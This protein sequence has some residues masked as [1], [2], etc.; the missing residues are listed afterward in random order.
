MRVKRDLPF[1]LSSSP[2]LSFPPS[3]PPPPPLQIAAVPRVSSER[4]EA[5][6]NRARTLLAKGAGACAASGD[7]S[8]KAPQEK[9][10]DMLIRIGVVTEAA[11]ALE[12][13]EACTLDGLRAAGKSIEGVAGHVSKWAAHWEGRSGDTADS[14]AGPRGSD[15]GTV[16]ELIPRWRLPIP[17][18][19]EV[20]EPQEAVVFWQCLARDLRIVTRVGGVER[21]GWGTLR[22]ILYVFAEGSPSLVPRT[23]MHMLVCTEGDGGESTVMTLCRGGGRGASRVFD[24]VAHVFRLKWRSASALPVVHLSACFCTCLCTAEHLQCS[25]YRPDVQTGPFVESSPD[26]RRIS[27]NAMSAGVMSPSSLASP[28][29]HQ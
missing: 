3:P 27:A 13:M 29:F 26:Y 19:V 23:L 17:R 2:L 24:A 18:Q 21:G 25:T 11:R 15:L 7:G 10:Q 28:I 6:F 8:A 22:D 4:G 20:M 14:G 9:C 12:A 1:L 5:S 16:P